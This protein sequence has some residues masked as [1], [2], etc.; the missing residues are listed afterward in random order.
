MQEFPNFCT[1]FLFLSV[2]ATCWGGPR[3]RQNHPN[4]ATA[5]VAPTDRRYELPFKPNYTTAI[6]SLSYN[7]GMHKFNPKIHHRRSIRLKGYDYTRPGSYFITVCVH[8]RKHWFGFIENGIMFPNAFG[9]IAAREWQALPERF[10]QVELKEFVIMPNHMHGILVVRAPVRATLAVAPPFFSDS[11][12]GVPL[13]GTPINT[14]TDTPITD[15]ENL[16]RTDNAGFLNMDMGNSVNGHPQGMPQLETEGETEREIGRY[17]GH[18]QGMPQRT[19]HLG[20]IIG[21]YKSIASVECLKYFK[22]HRPGKRLGKLLQ[23]DYWEHI[24]RDDRAYYNISNYI[25][26]N[27]KNWKKDC[28]I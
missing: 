23:R 7:R 27:P 12:V 13:A 20:E 26:N 28:F 2:G 14:P 6:F 3:G 10:P 24:I 19:Y 21:A 16:F 8:K 15:I 5:R 22:I 4:W 25:L 9:K 18:P 1:V 11:P 17:D